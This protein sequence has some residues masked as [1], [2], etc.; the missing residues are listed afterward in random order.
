MS[1]IMRMR[2]ATDHH[3]SVFCTKAIFSHKNNATT[4]K[5]PATIIAFRTTFLST[6]N[7]RTMFKKRL[8]HLNKKK[9]QEHARKR[10]RSQDDDGGNT[11]NSDKDDGNDNNEE[12]QSAMEAI[13]KAQQR[14]KLLS[15]LPLTSVNGNRGSSSRTAAAK[16][17]KT[18]GNEAEQPYNEPLSLLA[19]K[20]QQAMEE[21]ISQKIDTTIGAPPGQ[22][23]QQQSS[24]D[25]LDETALYREL[26]QQA[27]YNTTTITSTTSDTNHAPDDHTGGRATKPKNDD[28][29]DGAVLVGGT[30]ITEVI[31]P[32]QTRLDSSLGKTKSSSS[33]ATAPL[34]SFP[35]GF[36]SAA[37]PQP[38]GASKS[39]QLLPTKMAATT[40]NTNRTMPFSSSQQQQQP[41]HPNAARNA[42][43]ADQEPAAS[44]S[45]TR[46]GFHAARNITVLPTTTMGQHNHHSNSNGQSNMNNHGHSNKGH[47]GGGPRPPQGQG[48]GSGG[49]GNT[50]DRVFQ[51]FMARQRDQNFK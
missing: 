35:S 37:P 10:E 42:T 33:A 2:G 18:K 4:R 15:S 47:Q 30:G 6:P 26:A 19:L 16:T 40:R 13:A 45:S 3:G 14:H 48:R 39:F 36:S 20:H 9:L 34:R 1:A 17:K 51:Q 28:D 12:G 29:R 27:A 21:F 5:T 22:P 38:H 44:S 31:L 50:D 49:G 25:P 41:Q 7:N 43:T 23:N 46:V 24:Q 32:L 11:R 8:I